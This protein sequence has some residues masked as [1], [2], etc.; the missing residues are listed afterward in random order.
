MERCAW[1][2]NALTNGS[3]LRWSTTAGGWQRRLSTTFSS[4]FSP[5]SA[6]RA[7]RE[8]AWVYPSPTRSLKVMEDRC[9]PVVRGR[10]GVVDLLFVSPRWRL[11]RAIE[12]ELTIH[13]LT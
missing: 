12:N 2:L 10:V 5:P 3:S 13:N 4:R 6:A 7:S 9:A 1:R 11:D 8:R